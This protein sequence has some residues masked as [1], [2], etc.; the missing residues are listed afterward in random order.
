MLDVAEPEGLHVPAELDNAG[1]LRDVLRRRER[2]GQPHRAGEQGR[3]VDSVFPA[4]V[5]G[6]LRFG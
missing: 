5:V 3:G 4:S 2:L 6:Q 1:E